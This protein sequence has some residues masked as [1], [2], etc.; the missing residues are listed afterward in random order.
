[1]LNE[2]EEKLLSNLDIGEA[3]SHVEY[4]ST[5]DKTS[6]TQGEREA[7]EYVRAKLDEYGVHYETYEFDSLIS[8]PKEAS[9]KVTSPT[10]MEVECITHAF[11][12][13]TPEEGFEAEL[14]F[15]P[16]SPSSLFT[17]LGDLVEEYKRS[18]VEGK[19]TL[20]FGV[21]SPAVVWAAQ[22]AGAIAQVHI[23]GG[24]VLHEMI[25]T[26]IWGTPTPEAAERIPE[27]TAVSVKRTDGEKLVELA[28]EGPV[29]ISLKA[30]SDTRWRSIPFTVAEIEGTE[31][32]EKFMLVHGHMDSWYLGTTDNCTGNAALLEL[33]R[34]LEKNKGGLKRSVRIAW[35]SGHSTGRYS[36]STWYADNLFHDLDRNC[37]LSMNID[38][39][40]VLGATELGGGGLMG[41]MDFVNRAAR[42]ATGVGEIEKQAYYMRAG[43][44]SF[45]GIGVPSV[46]VRAYIPEGS[47]HR[48]Q[49]IGGSGG[50]WWWHSPYDTLDKGDRDHLLRDMRMEALAVYR[51]V[52]AGVLPFDF[53]EVAGMYEETLVE[54]KERTSGAFDLNPTLDRIGELK[55]RSERMN[56]AI[57]GLDESKAP[58]VNDIL[59]RVS[60]IL[61]STFYTQAGPF[62]QDPA[63]GIS[64]LPALQ[65][66]ARLAGL[67]PVS[68]EAGF[69]RTRLIREAN[70]V[71]KALDAAIELISEATRISS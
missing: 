38:S 28:K 15:V 41:T 10:A 63:Y 17:G 18:N 20:M 26:T 12:K 57:A 64:H 2:N 4:L 37:F 13:S 71:N 36:A 29:K 6:A 16:V 50:A 35:W 42:D 8:H 44:Q 22:Q 11:S 24:D 39:P 60:K 40:G 7:H 1:V 21:A 51:S 5:L 31:E 19:V 67:D 49:W 47:L 65:D 53:S 59:S 32:P 23:C 45:Y 48:G 61:T 56:E 25:V 27:I 55:S 9:L 43:D 46:A 34:I 66:A 33:A 70:R 68:G 58:E 3:W 62:D 30:R 69:L 52:N 54:I 14:V